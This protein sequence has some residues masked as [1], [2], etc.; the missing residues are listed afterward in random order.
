MKCAFGPV[1]RF[2]RHQTRQSQEGFAKKYGFDRTYISELE[3]ARRVPSL[4]TLFR[5]SPGLNVS[6]A[7]MVAMTALRLKALRNPGFDAT[8]PPGVPEFPYVA[9]GRLFPRDPKLSA[10]C[11]ALGIVART[12]R[13]RTGAPQRI[14]AARAAMN[15][16]YVSTIERGHNNASLTMLFRLSNGVGVT[17]AFLVHCVGVL[18]RA[19]MQRSAVDKLMSNIPVDMTVPLSVDFQH[20]RT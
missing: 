4:E 19:E 18:I 3:R 9:T 15:H 2:L 16:T 1:L 20:T 12:L 8:A 6:P 10:L 14:T 13:K 7:L 5:L 17:A 11:E